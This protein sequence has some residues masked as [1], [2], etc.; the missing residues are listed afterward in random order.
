LGTHLL[1]Y[2]LQPFSEEK[3][4][5]REEKNRLPKKEKE[6]NREGLR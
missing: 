5:R 6:K 4:E 1:L 3:G 2:F